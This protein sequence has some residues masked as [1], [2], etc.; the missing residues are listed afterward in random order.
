MVLTFFIYK[1]FAYDNFSWMTHFH[2]IGEEV[3]IFTELVLTRVFCNDFSMT[4]TSDSNINSN[5]WFY[6]KF[7]L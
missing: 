1:D 7:V 3:H 2:K 4:V 5:F 6:F